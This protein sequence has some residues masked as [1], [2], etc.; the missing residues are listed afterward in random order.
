MQR[1]AIRR[2]FGESARPL[3]PP[4]VLELARAI[5]P[6]VGAATIYRSL[7]QFVEEGFL[8]PVELPGG[9]TL[10]ERAGKVHHHHFHCTRCDRVYD[11]DGCGGKLEKLAPSGFLVEGHDLTLTGACAT[12]R[13]A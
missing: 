4:Q 3:S 6:S 2:V 8:V 7:S 1:D 11:V 13:A 9:A 12:C 5:V 10:Y